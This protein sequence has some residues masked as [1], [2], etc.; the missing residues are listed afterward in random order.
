ALMGTHLQGTIQIRFYPP[1][2]N[3][4]HFEVSHPGN[5]RGDDTVLKAPQFY[6]MAVQ[7]NYILD[8]FTNLSSGDLNLINGDVSNLNYR[9]LFANSFYSALQNANPRLKGGAF[10]FPGGYGS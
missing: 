8:P 1:V 2:N 10:E 5:L 9:A 3:I 4:A 6:E 7:E